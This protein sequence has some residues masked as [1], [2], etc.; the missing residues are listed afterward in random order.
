MA[1][2]FRFKELP[3]PVSSGANLAGHSSSEG[4]RGD[5]GFLVCSKLLQTRPD[6]GAEYGV[7]DVGSEIRTDPLKQCRDF[8]FGSQ[9][10]LLPADWLLVVK[11]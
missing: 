3:K 2:F 4:A 11:I 9:L 8:S 6:F 10:L 7:G 5:I 1:A